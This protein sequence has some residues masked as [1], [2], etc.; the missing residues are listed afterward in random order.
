VQ[1]PGDI[2]GFLQGVSF[3]NI[4]DV[5]FANL[6]TREVST[7]VH[8]LPDG[9]FSGFVPVKE[10]RNRVRVTALASDGSSGSVELELLFEPSGMTEKE[11]AL[12]LERI[13][14]HNKQL[15]LLVEQERIRRFREQQRKVIE[16][17]VEEPEGGGR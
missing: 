13:R 14:E 8:L 16:L 1:R 3:S 2:I 10:G 4:E 15:Q 17:E 9:T 6:T 11:L 12:E 5:V 7:D